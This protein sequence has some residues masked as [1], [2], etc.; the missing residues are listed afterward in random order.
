MQIR[1]L[2]GSVLCARRQ[3][4]GLARRVSTD[5]WLFRGL[6]ISLAAGEQLALQGASGGGKSTLLNLLAGLDQPG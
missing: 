6:N 4:E 5:F 3:A 1:A 2:I